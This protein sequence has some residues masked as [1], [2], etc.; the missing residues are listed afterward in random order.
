[1]RLI[2]ILALALI[3]RSVSAQDLWDFDPIAATPPVILETKIVM[4]SIDGCDGCKQ[5][6]RSDGIDL[7]EAG[8]TLAV[9]KVEPVVD[10]KY[11]RWRVCIDGEC[12]RI[13]Y[14][15]ISKSH[16]ASIST[17]G[18]GN[19]TQ[20]ANPSCITVDKATSHS[21]MAMDSSVLWRQVNG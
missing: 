20:R 12:G 4:E 2:F 18:G 17:R 11:P 19:D 21:R 8:W 9:K 15:K 10:E 1:M 5:W 14:T 7:L 6:L 13:A 16:C 3:T